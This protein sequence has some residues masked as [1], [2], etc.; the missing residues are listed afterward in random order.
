MIPS[1]QLFNPQPITETKLEAVT[2][3]LSQG[4][5]DFAPLAYVE[6]ELNQI[7]LEIPAQTLLNREFTTTNFKSKI[8]NSQK[9]I[10]HVATHGQ[11]SSKAED[12][13]ILAWDRPIN[14]NQLNSVFQIRPELQNS[15][16]LL[17]LSACETATGDD[18]AAL[19][20]AGVALRSGARSALASLWLVNDESTAQ[21]MNHFYQ[22]LN[23]GVTRGEALR[24]AQQTLLREPKYSHPRY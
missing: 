1:L 12:T 24:R 8:R 2:V 17:V 16:E 9:S 4:R 6:Q 10:V 13:F 22:Q 19:E 5:F 23:T 18:R 20:I 7:E 3:G 11:F 21:L 14:V 15:L